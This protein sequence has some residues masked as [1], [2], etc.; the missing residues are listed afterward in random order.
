MDAGICVLL[1]SMRKLLAAAEA[2]R[3]AQDN[4]HF[5]CQKE[6]DKLYWVMCLT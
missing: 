4:L 6:D 5:P 2:G 1:E 3:I